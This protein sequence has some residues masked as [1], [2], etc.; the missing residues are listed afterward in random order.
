M[1][2]IDTL[3]PETYNIFGS[4]NIK[5]T[6]PISIFKGL[7][8]CTIGL[9][10]LS[11]LLTKIL[12]GNYSSVNQLELNNLSIKLVGQDKQNILKM[13]LE[14]FSENTK[15]FAI[16]LQNIIDN[17]TYTN[18]LFIEL[19]N[20]Y[21]QNMSNFKQYT[22]ILNTYMKTD[23][24][25][26]ISTIYSTYMFYKN[27]IEHKY[28]YNETQK[29]LY[30]IFVANITDEEH[31]TFFKLF[32]I[33][34][35]YNWFSQTI[36]NEKIRQ[37]YF[38]KQLDQDF[39]LSNKIF[40][41]SFLE[42]INKDV[43]QNIKSL[44]IQDNSQSES[45]NIIIKNITN[46]IK[47]SMKMGD[48]I[49][50]MINYLKYLQTRLLTSNIDPFIEN[51]IIKV[52]QYHN[53]PELYIKMK[54]C[55]QDLILSKYITKVIHNLPIINPTSAK[56]NLFDSSNC[57]K[58]IC[59]YNIIRPYSWNDTLYG[60]YENYGRLNEPATISYYIDI[61]DKYI[62]HPDS[63][64][65]DLFKY[66]KIIY[67]YINSIGTFNL[68]L[69]SK[70][71]KLTGNL[72]QI[73]VLMC[74]NNNNNSIT[75]QHVAEQIKIPIK[76]LSPIFNSLLKINL[77]KRENTTSNNDVGMKFTLNIDW[78]TTDTLFSLNDVYEQ[79]K[80]IKPQQ[81]QIT[82]T[83]CKAKLIAFFVAE[84][85][86]INI[87]FDLIFKYIQEQKLNI[88]ESRLKLILTSMIVS[89]LITF[90]NNVYSY[91][92]QEDSDDEVSQD[93]TSEI[94]QQKNILDNIVSEQPNVSPTV[95]EQPVNSSPSKVIE[96]LNQK[97]DLRLLKKNMIHL[98]STGC[99]TNQNYESI[100]MIMEVSDSTLKI[101]LPSLIESGIIR[102]ENELYI[103]NDENEE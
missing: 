98:F 28:N 84:K 38:N 65:Y 45:N 66:R 26:Y 83:M 88:T 102:L 64:V 74:I 25:K 69:N 14:L 67:D 20:K 31:E 63:T 17:N 23:T 5:K 4:I 60:K 24:G 21:I 9:E 12:N 29:N 91:I 68:T 48:K 36:L 90:N 76:F 41:S 50:F 43:D 35:Y 27:V 49:I 44:K 70:V 51:A 79:V 15:N 11:M 72:L 80:N 75:A 2:S 62:I 18:N 87:N 94:I 86:N 93:K 54:F 37:T 58:Q 34:N 8:T 81:V 92:E 82:D 40:S 52:L 6:I 47:T 71:Y 30:E 57:N 32:K 61:F 97:E 42:L 56:Y 22:Y 33:Y 53:G 85:N 96:H 46:Y 78:T 59:K 19:Y 100:K 1:T 99:I 13:I 103:Y 7:T 16:I 39:S 101:L 95:S 73:I 89:N 3:S 55:I 77:I 10:R